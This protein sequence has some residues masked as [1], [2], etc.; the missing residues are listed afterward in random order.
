MFSLKY[1]HVPDFSLKRP[2]KLDR[3]LRIHLFTGYDKGRLV[4]SILKLGHVVEAIII[5]S[6][7]KYRDG[8][9]KLVEL[10]ESLGIPVHEVTKKDNFAGLPK[11]QTV[12]VLLSV[13][14]PLIVPT[15]VIESYKYAV[16]LHPTLLPRHRGKY[17]H[18]VLI[19][20]DDNSGV[21][22]HFMDA[23][24]DTGD[25]I[26][27][28]IF[29]VSPFDTVKSLRRKSEALEESLVAD[30]LT[31]L[32]AN[33]FVATKQIEAESSTHVQNRTPDDSQIDGQL[34]LIQLMPQIRA[35]DPDLYPAFFWYMGE[36]V[37]IRVW[38]TNKTDDEFDMI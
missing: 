9:D 5:P 8:L 16:N 37:F 14:F 38:R 4:R 34:P 13:G 7:P 28:R 24:T 19:E 18:Y 22:A 21:T 6:Q 30:V 17:L 1:G 35:A 27:Q 20:N 11:S 36:K 33:T 15:Q 32:A 29:A 25:I 23:G 12:E 3:E 26:G 31:Q 2:P 10:S